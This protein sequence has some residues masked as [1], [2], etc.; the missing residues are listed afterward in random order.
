MSWQKPVRVGLAIF[1]IVFVAIVVVALR[2]RRHAAAPDPV[3]GRSGVGTVQE[4]HGGV[5]L[6]R[7]S[8]DGKVVVAIKSE[9]ELLYPDGRTVLQRVELTLPDRD[10]RSIHV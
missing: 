8:K 4:T 9:S 1:V 6:N 7:L 10:G 5:E 3:A 2:Q